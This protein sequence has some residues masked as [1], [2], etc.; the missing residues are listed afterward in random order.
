MLITDPTFNAV[1]VVRLAAHLAKELGIP[2]V[3]LVIN[4]VR[5][6]NDIRKVQDL[7]GDATDLFSG[8]FYLPYDESLMAC[9]PDVRPILT[10]DSPFIDSFRALRLQLETSRVESRIN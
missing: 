5:S 10:G 6:E 4:R 2:S 9:E 3:Y 1:Q 7:L 8:Q